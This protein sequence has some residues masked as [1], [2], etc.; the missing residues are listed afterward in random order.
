MFTFLKK[1][2][3]RWSY[4]FSISICSA[5]FTSQTAPLATSPPRRQGVLHC[6]L[7]SS[8]ASLH[9]CIVFYPAFDSLILSFKNSRLKPDILPA[10]LL[11]CFSA[12]L[13]F[14]YC[15]LPITCN[16]KSS[17]S[18]IR[19]C[20][21]PPHPDSAPTFTNHCCLSLKPPFVIILPLSLSL[22]PSWPTASPAGTVQRARSKSALCCG[23]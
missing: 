6:S 18:R 8:G 13:P 21:P 5:A 4:L 22:P 7:L 23:S 3:A 9:T 10:S 15:H 19:F 1:P 17:G 20:P 12:M 16:C 2:G 11:C 14:R